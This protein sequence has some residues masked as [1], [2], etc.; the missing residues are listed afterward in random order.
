[1]LVPVLPV[2]PR[3]EVPPR[4]SLPATTRPSTLTDA[5]EVLNPPLT[6]GR[7]LHRILAPHH[8]PL[9]LA[10]LLP[11]FLHYRL[12]N[13]LMHESEQIPTPRPTPPVA[14]GQALVEIE[15]IHPVDRP[16]DLHSH[17]QVLVHPRPL[18]GPMGVPRLL[19]GARQ[20]LVARDRQERGMGHLLI[21]QIIHHNLGLAHRPIHLRLRPRPR[22]LRPP[23]PPLYQ[24][25]Q[26]RRRMP[27]VLSA[28]ESH[29]NPRHSRSNLPSVQIY[30]SRQSD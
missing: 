10:Y 25:L 7:L 28:L 29:Q 22:H 9:L 14:R 2:R 3:V 8:L 16:V 26:V 15:T 24:L 6:P 19:K 21:A 27:Q 11:P 30:L 17:P 5:L 18:L 4:P 12:L 23:Q 13:P 1:M 20:S